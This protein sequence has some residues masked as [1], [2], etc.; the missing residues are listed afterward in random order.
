MIKLTSLWKNKTK[1]GNT[2]L[3]GNIGEATILIFTNKEKKN[4][5]SP[6]FFMFLAEKQ[7]P[8]DKKPETEQPK[9]SIPF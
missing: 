6:D 8:E 2:Y 9:D 5:N 7:K 1:D 4:E 3:K